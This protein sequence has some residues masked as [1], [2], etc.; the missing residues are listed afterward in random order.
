MSA[1]IKKIAASI[2]AE[3]L[4]DNASHSHRMQ[5]RS[6]SSNRLYVVARN[7]KTLEWGCSCPGWIHAK[8][9]VRT[10]KHMRAIMPALQALDAA[11]KKLIG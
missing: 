2:Q 9:G 11:E 8:G 6:E 3:V 1:L 5:I 4:P 10:C 7:K